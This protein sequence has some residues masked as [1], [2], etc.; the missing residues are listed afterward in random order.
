MMLLLLIGF[1]LINFIDVI[2]TAIKWIF[3]LA[4]IGGGTGII[5]LQYVKKVDLEKAL[6]E[7]LK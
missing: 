1:T 7:M 2:L 6:E 4:M 5:Y 3:I